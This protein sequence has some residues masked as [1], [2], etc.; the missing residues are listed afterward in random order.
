[1]WK[2]TNNVC[3]SALSDYYIWRK[4]VLEKKQPSDSLSNFLICKP[5]Q[6][7]LNNSKLFKLMGSNAIVDHYMKQK[8]K[9]C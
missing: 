3:F 6:H 1:M 9:L 7:E 8:N 2:T 5:Q 4:Q